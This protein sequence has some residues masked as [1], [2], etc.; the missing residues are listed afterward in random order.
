MLLFSVYFVCQNGQSELIHCT[1]VGRV[2]KKMDSKENSSTVRSRMEKM[3]CVLQSSAI[4][5]IR[6]DIQCLFPLL[7]FLLA[8]S[9]KQKQ[10]SSL[11]SNPILQCPL[12][13]LILSHQV[14]PCL[15]QVGQHHWWEIRTAHKYIA[16]FHFLKTQW[17]VSQDEQKTR[18]V[19]VSGESQL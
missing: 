3:F 5:Q 16:A 14:W 6:Y 10:S 1:D 12:V 4:I 15:Q 7:I 13:V 2:R 18:L 8:I 17:I 19:S 9:M 11:D